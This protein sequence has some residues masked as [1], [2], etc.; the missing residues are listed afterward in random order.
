LSHCNTD[1]FSI[2]PH[3]TGQTSITGRSHITIPPEWMPRCRGAS[4]ISAASSITDAG[5]LLFLDAA[6]EA[7][8]GAAVPNRVFASERR[9]SACSRIVDA[10]F[11][12]PSI[13]FDQ[14]SCWPIS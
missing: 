9:D 10:M 14:A 1:R 4:S 3:S 5:M 8:D 13:C 2:R 12:H 6:G 11:P 7:P